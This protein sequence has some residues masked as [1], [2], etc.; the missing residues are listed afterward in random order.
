MTLDDACPFPH[1]KVLFA[2][3]TKEMSRLQEDFN[4][5]TAENVTACMQQAIWE[6]EL[7]AANEAYSGYYFVNWR[8]EFW[9]L[10]EYV[11]LN[12]TSLPAQPATYF[13]T[14]HDKAA[15]LLYERLDIEQAPFNFE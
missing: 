10:Q 13:L 7:L 9:P 5:V 3:A 11:Q 1:R 2:D 8:I 15:D 4:M 6:F 14:L 12:Q